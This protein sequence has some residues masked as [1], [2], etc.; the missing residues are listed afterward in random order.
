MAT[1]VDISPHRFWYKRNLQ[2]AIQYRQ[3]WRAYR[4]FWTTEAGWALHDEQTVRHDDSEGLS[5][6]EGTLHQ[7]F[8]PCLP[9][10]ASFFTKHA[11]KPFPFTTRNYYYIIIM[12]LA[13]IMSSVALHPLN[14]YDEGDTRTMTRTEIL[15]RS[16]WVRGM[17]RSYLN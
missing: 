3:P 15:L 5:R 9:C 6:E 16:V 11:T 12:R 7:T 4:R 8:D 1:F 2:M 17:G 14:S 13:T 10:T